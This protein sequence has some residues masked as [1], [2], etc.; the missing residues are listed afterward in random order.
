MVYTCLGTREKIELAT[1]TAT[2]GELDANQHSTSEDCVHNY[3]C[4]RLTF[5]LLMMLFSDAVKEGDSAALL[6]FLKVALLLLHSYSKVCICCPFVS[7]K[8]KCYFE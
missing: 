7:C 6:K 1:P 3:H 8:S 5:G 4:A 2:D